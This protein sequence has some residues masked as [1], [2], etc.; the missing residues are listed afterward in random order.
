[1]LI[2]IVL[3]S[4]SE[5]FPEEVFEFWRFLQKAMQGMTF[6]HLNGDIYIWKCY[7][8]KLFYR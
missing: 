7:K 8:L 2:V 6:F 3:Q 1:M 5:D 4:E